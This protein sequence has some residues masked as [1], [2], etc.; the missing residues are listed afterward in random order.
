[1][2]SR[3]G[4]ILS[5]GVLVAVCVGPA[6]AA[7]EGSHA[8]RYLPIDHWAYY[9]IDRLQARGFLSDLDPLV[10]PYRRAEVADGLRSVTTRRLRD[11]ERRWMELLREEFGAEMFRERGR[12]RA[13]DFRIGADLVAGARGANQDR[14][15][16]LRPVGDGA[17]WPNGE[18]G[19]WLEA[20][21]AVAVSR[22]RSDAW[23]P[24]DPDGED[25]G[26]RL[27]ARSQEAYV[28]LQLPV[29]SFTVGR[30][31][32]NWGPPGAPGLMISPE[33][34][35]YA[36][37]GF[38][39]EAGPIRW[40]SLLA[41]LDTLGPARRWLAAHRVD[42]RPSPDFALSFGES[43][44]Q[45]GP[46]VGLSPRF[47]NP[48]SFFFFDHDNQPNDFVMNLML[49]FQVWFRK[50]G[51]VLYAEGLIDDI[52]VNPPEGAESTEP[53]QYA[54]RAGLRLPGLSRGLD[55]SLSY[56]LASAF[57]YRTLRNIDDY[58]FLG[59][60]LG[61]NFAD[62]DRVEAR[63]DLHTGTAGLT[64]SPILA[65]QREGEGDI[66]APID[67]TRAEWRRQPSLFL[68]TKEKT[69]RAGLA[70][71]LQPGRALWLTWDLGVNFVSD[72]DHVE[73]RDETEF[74]GVG[75]LTLRLG[76]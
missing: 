27:E 36:Q 54:L 19:V 2:K 50:P 16:P 62:F 65:L 48:L 73:G 47:L 33:P 59:R 39:L 24:D 15:D 51:F 75:E 14:F 52:D 25:V 22:V 29:V 34:A 17:V 7:Q 44:L 72:A 20:G 64:L 70:G 58:R 37:L 26:R 13:D 28:A 74:A 5:I 46:G 30:L 67:L 45:A 3:R 76:L 71:R 56:T 21:P 41:E 35:T 57:V 49:D 63:L 8:S 4:V 32:R 1:M 61:D 18:V 38:D 53:S 23:F 6:R 10:R 12:G 40:H 42:L 60:G 31:A 9:Y 11:P 68:G 69:F 55:L 66:R 43:I